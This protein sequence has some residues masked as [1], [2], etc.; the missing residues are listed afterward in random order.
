MNI[1]LLDGHTVQVLPMAKALRKKNY[2]VSV[3]C[4]EKLSF[5]WTSRY[6][7][8]KILSPKVM[9]ETEKYLDFL[10][11]HLKSNEYD[12][13]IPL[14]DDTAEIMSKYKQRFEKYVKIA[15]PDYDIF[16]QAHDKNL[17]MDIA[18]KINIPHPKTICL[19][20]NSLEEASIYCG[21]PSLI[22]PN[23]AAGARGI[24]QVNT[25]DELK[26]I[27]KNHRSEFG[28]STLQE[29]IEQSDF[30]YNCQIFRDQNGIIKAST[31][32]KKYRYFPIS[33]GTIS[34]SETVDVSEIIKHSTKVLDYLN[35]VGFADFDF[36]RDPNDKEYK[37]IEI[38][39][40]IPSSIRACFNAEVDYAEL[41]IKDI[42][43]KNTDYYKTKPGVIMRSL[44]LD[45]LW[46]LYSTNKERFQSKPSWFSFFGTNICYVDVSM[47]EPIASFIGFISGVNKYLNPSFR[48][49]KL[50]FKTEV[51]K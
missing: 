1:L 12:V 23:I 50:S 13:L 42:L 31:V 24:V 29:F 26:K 7:N 22:K 43:G 27:Y 3:F 2:N 40:R 11:E 5:G 39:P 28:A 18:K 36:I 49:S 35:W 21:F 19:E 14:F 51:Q 44:S 48:K 6:I 16:I 10:E 15:I 20:T 45:I 34:C 37:I 46:F 25:Q 17:T 47:D 9:D 32:Q 30:Q 8:T 33:G 38:N 41:I 4:E